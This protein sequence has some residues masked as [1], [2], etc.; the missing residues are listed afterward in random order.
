MFARSRVVEALLRDRE[1]W[2][3]EAECR[4]PFLPND[5][6]LARLLRFAF[7]PDVLAVCGDVAMVDSY[8]DDRSAGMGTSPIPPAW[9]KLMKDGTA[10]RGLL[11]MRILLRLGS[12]FPEEEVR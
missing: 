8:F 12:M 1:S 9:S 10:T 5:H 3:N 7:V 2:S 4:N 11:D 6:I